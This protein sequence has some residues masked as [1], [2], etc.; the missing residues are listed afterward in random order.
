MEEAAVYN[1]A[2]NAAEVLN[3]YQAFNTAPTAESGGPYAVEEGGAVTLDA[4]AS[5]DPQ[6]NITTYEW[7]FDYDGTT[8][9]VDA[10]G[11][12]PTFDASSLQN[13]STR[14]IALRVTDAG[15]LT[16]FDITT[17]SVLGDVARWEFTEGT[18]L[19]AAD[20]VGTNDGTL[21]NG[22]VWS[23]GALDGSLVFDGV[24]DYVTVPNSA[25]LNPTS[26]LSVEAL[27]KFDAVDNSY[28]AI[29]AKG[30]PSVSESY[31][32][33]MLQR[34]RT[35]DLTQEWQGKF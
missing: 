35:G 33:Y 6:N 8:F 21:V 10:T 25:L 14:T 34:N 32:T 4:S 20:S 28:D 13:A 7:D 22:P 19:V 24:N 27:V 29:V 2:L 12:A 5:T 1:R 3:R 16:D 30:S 31:L 17:L 23:A 15:G 26:Q 18:G 9:D 11:V